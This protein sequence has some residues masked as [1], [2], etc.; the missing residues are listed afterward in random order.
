MAEQAYHYGTGRRKTSS[1][2][3]RLYPGQG[4]VV[5]NGRPGQDYFPRDGDLDALL[6]PLTAV[7]LRENF[8]V[9]VKVEG[10][11]ISGQVGAV[12]HGIARALLEF[13]PELRPTLKRGG[14][15]TRDPRMKERK[16]PGLKRARRAPQYTKR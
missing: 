4:T 10:G 13:D 15:L 5:V 1:A 14:F 12:R 11:G 9:V 2:R 16:K 3:V 6:E 8:D 7:N